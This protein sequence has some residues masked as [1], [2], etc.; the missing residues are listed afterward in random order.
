[1]QV[2]IVGSPLETAMALDKRRLNKQIL[3]GHQILA[4][5]HGETKAWANHPVTRMYSSMEGVAWLVKYLE[6]LEVYRDGN[7]NSLMLLNY[8]ANRLR[9]PFHTQ[10]YFDHM[11]LRLYVKDPIHYKQYAKYFTEGDPEAFTNWYYVDNQ[12]IKYKQS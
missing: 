11:K 10:E 12:W 4:A 2:F 3:E 6:V 9:L 7:F 5:I 8:E 1:M